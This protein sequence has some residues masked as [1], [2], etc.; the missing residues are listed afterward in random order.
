MEIAIVVAMAS[1]GSIGMAAGALG[2]RRIEDYEWDSSPPW[3]I[4]T[5][6]RSIIAVCCTSLAFTLAGTWMIMLAVTRESIL[7]ITPEPFLCWAIGVPAVAFFGPVCLYS[8][9]V[10]AFSPQH[11]F[12]LVT[13]DDHYIVVWKGFDKPISIHWASIVDVSSDDLSSSI[14]NS[15][16]ILSYT[17]DGT[18]IPASISLPQIGL[19]IGVRSFAESIRSAAGWCGD[20]H[21]LD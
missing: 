14:I 8:F 18:N 9:L 10:V 4:R 17:I 6:L 20:S 19:G 15:R 7:N 1:F 3:S 12:T 16:V 11:S 2:A 5:S 21:D 13:A